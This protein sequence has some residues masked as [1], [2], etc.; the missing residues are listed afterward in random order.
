MIL[1]FIC[2]IGII[3]FICYLKRGNG[4]NHLIESKDDKNLADGEIWLKWLKIIIIIFKKLKVFKFQIK[5]KKK[6]GNS[7]WILIKKIK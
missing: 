6:N 4:N 5:C 1:N 7:K 3:L 2:L